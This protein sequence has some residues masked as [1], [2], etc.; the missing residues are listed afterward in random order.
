MRKFLLFFL[1][2]SSTLLAKEK[3]GLLFVGF[4][5]GEANIWVQVLKNWEGAP[6]AQV[7][8][9]ST[10]SKVAKDAGLDHVIEIE[11]L[12]ITLNNQRLSELS[13]T[14]LEKIETLCAS[15]L[16]TGMY[17]TPARQIAEVFAAK[18]SK[19]IAAWDNFST[20]DKL[21]ADLVANV[22]KIVRVADRILVPSHEI[23]HDLNERFHMD[24]AIAAGQPTLEMWEAKIAQVDR[25][26]ALS[27]THFCPCAPILTY[28]SGYEENGNGYHDSFVTFAHSLNMLKTPLQVIVQLHPRSDGS[29]EQKILADFTSQNPRFPRYFISNGKQLSTFESVAV[30]DLG[31]C[32]RS[33][34]AIQALFAGKRFMHIDVPGTPFSHFAIEKQLI[35]QCL[36]SDEA[37]LYI[38]AH[39][40][41]PVNTAA[42]YE[43]AGIPQKSTQIFRAML[44]NLTH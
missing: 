30:S 44:N 20:Y 24:K 31:V 1:V 17:S 2:L 18:G 35:P 43:Q 37:A 25:K 14:D 36:S 7:L 3:S 6:D 29:F 13:S 21:P 39:L 8:V 5:A 38:S 26:A 19:V 12:G 42:L 23:A 10:A 33:T 9:M 32:Q 16:V 4:D 28:I 40:K 15:V 22:E 41:D 27:K 34:V 11:S